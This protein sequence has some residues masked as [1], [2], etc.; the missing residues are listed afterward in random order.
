MTSLVCSVAVADA[1]GMDETG[2]AVAEILE[3]QDGVIS[4]RQAL[5]CDLAVHD[6]RRLL[7]RK[8]WARVHP[9]VYVDHTGPLTWRQRA[10]AAVLV[11]APAALCRESAR[12][13][14]DGPGRT[15]HDDGKVIHVAVTA[16]RV[17]DP[18]PGVEVH[19]L[20][21]VD[22]KVLWHTSPPRQRIEHAVIDLAGR[23]PRGI[24]AIGHLADAVRARQTTAPRLAAALADR[25]RIGR[26]RFLSEV[27]ADIGAGTCSA[28]EHGY[29]A[30]VERPHGLPVARRQMRESIKGPLYRDAVYE[31]FGAIIELDGRLHHS[32]TQA[33]DRD[34]ERDLDAF[35]TGRVTARLGWGQ[36]FDRPCRTAQKVAL[37]LHNRGWAG[38]LRH[39]PRCP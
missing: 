4:R 22:Q 18:P 12:R 35:V 1:A 17:I 39:C 29:L 8:E 3:R 2:R 6:I 16:S 36:V 25:T 9:G 37:A 30:R 13:A 38:V 7:R 28:L 31:E 33:R 19:R 23:A 32:T 27:I 14:A 5:A 11:C 10:W 15:T 20:T 26:R 34:L 24:D 21:D